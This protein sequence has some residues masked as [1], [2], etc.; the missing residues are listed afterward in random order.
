MEAIAIRLETIATS[1]KNATIGGGQ[2]PVLP[3][4]VRLVPSHVMAGH[5]AVPEAQTGPS[6]LA[7]IA[8][9]TSGLF[10]GVTLSSVQ[11]PRDPVLTEPQVR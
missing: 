10:T 3:G 5:R 11:L 7:D 1:N 6:A 4:P 8:R 2:R 9:Q